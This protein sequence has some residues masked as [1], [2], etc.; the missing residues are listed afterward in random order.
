MARVNSLILNFQFNQSFAA[1][2]ENNNRNFIHDLTIKTD[3]KKLGTL[4]RNFIHDPTII[5]DATKMNL[6]K[7]LP[8]KNYR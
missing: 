3:A 2:A 4:Y 8:G 1:D 6:I 7:G 5:T